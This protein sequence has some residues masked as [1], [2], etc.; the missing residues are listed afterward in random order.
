MS[1]PSNWAE[2]LARL[3]RRLGDDGRDG[4]EWL[5]EAVEARWGVTTLRDLDRG[6]RQ[7]AFQKASGVLLAIEEDGLPDE[8][9]DPDGVLPPLLLYRDGSI[10]PADGYPGRRAAVAAIIARY[11]DGV[12]VEGPPWQVTPIEE[13]PT[14]AEYAGEAEFPNV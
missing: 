4:E 9:V 3:A 14:Y 7:I 11:F 2:L 10:E 6:G 1:L 13:R 12:V 5:R 8:L